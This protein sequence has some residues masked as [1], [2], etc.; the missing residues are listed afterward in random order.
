MYE[1]IVQSR[2]ERCEQKLQER[3]HATH[4]K[5]VD[6]IFGTCHEN[7]G[8]LFIPVFRSGA[9]SQSQ[10][11]DAEERE[12]IL[13]SD[14]SVRMMG[15]AWRARYHHSFEQSKIVIMANGTFRTT[16]QVTVYVKDLNMSVIVQ[17][18]KGFPAVLSFGR[19]CE[20]H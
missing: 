2:T 6:K 10:V 17:L 8:T 7:N 20:E 13:D 19:L 15:H 9:T 18:L 4:V 11:G 5:E 12:I 3:R 14:A 1:H 16:E